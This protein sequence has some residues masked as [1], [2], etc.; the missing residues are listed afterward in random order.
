VQ[1][2]W[3][4]DKAAHLEG[5]EAL[6]YATRTIGEEPQLVLWGGGNSSAKVDTT[7]HCGRDIRVLWIKGSGADMRTITPNQFTPLRLDDLCLLMGRDVMSDEEMVAY[8]DRCIL[9]PRAPKPSIETLLH[10]FL[11]APHVYH[12]HA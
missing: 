6:V 10:A 9:D 3:S 12:T 5:L 8:L 2:R 4:D 11:P 1:S 7:D